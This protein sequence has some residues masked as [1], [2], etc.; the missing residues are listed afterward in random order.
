MLANVEALASDL[1]VPAN[2]TRHVPSKKR[3]AG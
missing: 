3:R 1:D 2:A